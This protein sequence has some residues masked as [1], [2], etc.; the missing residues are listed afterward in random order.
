MSRQSHDQ[1]YRKRQARTRGKAEAEEAEDTRAM[2]RDLVKRGLASRDIL[3]DVA[4]WQRN[5][6][7][8]STR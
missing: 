6:N 8:R 4:P 7:R 1:G 5:S 2:A 3:H